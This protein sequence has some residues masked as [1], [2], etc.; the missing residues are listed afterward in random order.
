MTSRWAPRIAAVA[1][2]LLWPVVHLLTAAPLLLLR[3]ARLRW[4]TSGFLV[5][6]AAAL[7]FTLADSFGDRMSPVLDL[8][9]P[10]AIRSP[11]RLVVLVVAVLVVVV[12][13]TVLGIRRALIFTDTGARAPLGWVLMVVSDIVR[14]LADRGYWTALHNDFAE[15][16]ARNGAPT[17]AEIVLVAHSLGTVIAVDHLRCFPDQFPSASIT[18]VT[19]GSPLR[20]I[21]ARFFPDRYDC[22]GKLH[23]QIAN[24]YEKF[25]WLNIYR[26]ASIPSARD[27]LAATLR[28]TAAPASGGA[29]PRGPRTSGIVRSVSL[30]HGCRRSEAGSVRQ[31][32]WDDA[33]VG[34]YAATRSATREGRGASAHR[35][36]VHRLVRRVSVCGTRRNALDTH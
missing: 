20:R 30:L 22:P 36:D 18:L 10:A 5:L 26:A 4:A 16:L 8:L 14:Y 28:L 6:F 9:T 2:P 3:T 33:A 1:L 25:R 31:A 12:G 34:L 24:Q 13:A 7:S 17:R 15:L 23:A 19:M 11:V 27:C 29:L 21:V 32:L 35:L